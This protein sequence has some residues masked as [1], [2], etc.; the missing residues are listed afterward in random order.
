MQIFNY[1][2]FNFND[3]KYIEQIQELVNDENINLL[4]K[5]HGNVKNC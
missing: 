3:F 2:K 4:I 5:D 1:K